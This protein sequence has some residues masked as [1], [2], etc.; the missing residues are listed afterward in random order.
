MIQQVQALT[1]AV[2]QL[3]RTTERQQETT[4]QVV[5]SHHSQ[6][7][8]PQDHCH[9]HTL[10]LTDQSWEIESS[11]PNRKLNVERGLGQ[12]VQDLEKKI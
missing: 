3:Q 11:I 8:T 10:D 2:Q 1:A 4:P 12:T 5:Q 6:Q 7:P 9:D